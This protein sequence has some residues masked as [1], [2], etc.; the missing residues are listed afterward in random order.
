M[1]KSSWL[2]G[3]TYKHTEKIFIEYKWT[4][5]IYVCVSVYRTNIDYNIPCVE[6]FFKHGMYKL[7]HYICVYGMYKLK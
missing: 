6:Y 1:L 4:V 7:K 3:Y 5:C 2:Q